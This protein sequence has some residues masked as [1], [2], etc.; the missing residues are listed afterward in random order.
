LGLVKARWKDIAHALH[1]PLGLITL[2]SECD[3]YCSV[4]HCL[5]FILQSCVLW[6]IDLFLGND[7]EVS[8][9][10]TAVDM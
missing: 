5:V 6:R 7:R 1:I 4:N 3:D 9:K 8:N 10:T 2:P